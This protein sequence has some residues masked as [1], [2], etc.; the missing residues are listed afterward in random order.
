MRDEEPKVPP[1]M[2]LI[3]EEDRLTIIEQLEAS[4]K[5][6]IRKIETMPV[7]LY[8]Q[9]TRKRKQELEERLNTIEDTIARF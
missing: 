7:S 6:T 2:K 1:G 8:T 5:E 4:R 3:N 9:S